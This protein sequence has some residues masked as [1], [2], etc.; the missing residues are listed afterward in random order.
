VK[1]CAIAWALFRFYLRLIPRRWYL[2]PPFLP[3]PPLDYLNWRL[4]T[5]Y[6]KHRPPWSEVFRDVWQ[7]GDWLRTFRQ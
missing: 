2:R 1:H 3:L 7:F 5:A 4:K 6:G